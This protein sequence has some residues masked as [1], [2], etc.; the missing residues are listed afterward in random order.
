M[1][2]GLAAVAAVLGAAA[3]LDGE[4]ARELYLVGV[5]VA[6]MDGLGTEQKVVEGQVVDR[7]RLGARPVVAH[8]LVASVGFFRSRGGRSFRAFRSKS[9][10]K[11]GLNRCLHREG[12]GPQGYFG[13]SGRG[14]EPNG[15]ISGPTLN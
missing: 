3:G 8:D 13:G 11:H 9:R 15:L 10:P 14:C 1:V 5:E 12:A 2:G 6:P 4:Q 7:L